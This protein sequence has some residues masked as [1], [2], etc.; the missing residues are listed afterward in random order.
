M[1]DDGL[2]GQTPNPGRSKP[3]WARIAIV[4]LLI[5]AC[6][7][8]ALLG[9]VTLA[10]W[11]KS[12]V[13]AQ[14]TATPTATPRPTLARTATP[15]RTPTPVPRPTATVIPGGPTPWVCTDLDQVKQIELARGQRFGCTFTQQQLTAKLAEVPDLP[16][17]RAQVVVADGEITLICQVLFEV[18]ISGVL[19]TDG[20]QPSLEITSGPA[21]F[22]DAL[23]S[24]AD[25][26]LQRIAGESVCIDQIVI[27]DGQI[28]IGGYGK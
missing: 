17:S 8:T 19:K 20:C 6:V 10:L 22:I 1:I 4:A 28:T 11:A 3:H 13:V 27:G 15:T 23:Q 16:C 2:E 25:Q 5:A 7:I 12:R 18:R 21:G 26:E 24:R 14:A 9:A